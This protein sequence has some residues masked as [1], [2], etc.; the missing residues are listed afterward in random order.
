MLDTLHLNCVSQS[1]MLYTWPI[2]IGQLGRVRVDS[3][4]CASR[5]RIGAECSDWVLPSIGR[6]GHKITFVLSFAPSFVNS[7]SI[8]R[9]SLER[10]KFMFKRQLR[11]GAKKKKLSDNRLSVERTKFTFKR[12]FRNGERREK[13]ER[14]SFEWARL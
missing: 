5:S 8:L 12:Q 6:G 3:T 11:N 9:E 1:Y 4:G 10:T 13:I 2:N 7:N 14:Q